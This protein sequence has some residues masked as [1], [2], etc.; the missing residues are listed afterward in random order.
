MKCTHCHALNTASDITCFGCGAPLAAQRQGTATPGWAY[1]FAV[2]CG[3]IPV[4]ALGGCVPV[5]L[6]I[7]GASG[8]LQ[9][10]RTRSIPGVLRV[11]LCVGITF[12]CWVVFGMLIVAIAAATHQ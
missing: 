8:C 11:G 6:G 9:V 7:G 4:V 3:L 2:I 10:A 5:A 1:V 12:V